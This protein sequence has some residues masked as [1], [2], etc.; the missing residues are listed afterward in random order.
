MF[1]FSGLNCINIKYTVFISYMCLN[2][3]FFTSPI[4][5]KK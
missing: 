5:K 3:F 2:K 4:A 1:G